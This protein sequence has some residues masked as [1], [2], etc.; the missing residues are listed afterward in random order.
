MSKLAIIDIEETERSLLSHPLIMFIAAT[1]FAWQIIYDASWEC[2]HSAW[3][4]FDQQNCTASEMT[5]IVLFRLLFLFFVVYIFIVVT[6]F[7]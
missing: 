5:N 1:T 7:C 2:M 6:K 3:I 4:I